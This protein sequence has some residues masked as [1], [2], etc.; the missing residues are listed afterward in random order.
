M[1]KAVHGEVVFVESK[2]PNGA[3]KL[4]VENDYYI[5]GESETHGNDHRV[6]V[7]D[8]VDIYELNS[9]LYIKNSVDTEVFCPNKHRHDTK[10][11]PAS[12]W[13]VKKAHDFDFLANEERVV[14]D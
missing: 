10:V 3:K 8:G 13:E 14:E 1:R 7:K 9:T 2:V 11:L 12:E 6:M 5:V 4:S